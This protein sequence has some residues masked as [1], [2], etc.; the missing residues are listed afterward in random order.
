MTVF[1]VIRHGP[2]GWNAVG[3]VQGRSDIALSEDGRAVV[4][5]WAVPPDLSGF[6]RVT[7]PLSRAVETAQILFGEPVPQDNRLV[8]MNWAEWEGQS[9]TALRAEIGDL[10]V[11]WEARGLDFRAPSGES[12]RDVQL[13]LATLLA[14]VA[15]TEKPVVAVTHKG[16]I[17]ALYALATGWDMTDKPSDKL[18]DDCVHLFSLSPGGI[19][20]V[21]R[22]NIPLGAGE[23]P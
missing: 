16:V 3:R 7:S 9:L 1:A 11:A 5:G 10:V 22:L 12:P 14:E 23:R 15:L 8:E 21:D 18:R 4:A 13:R 20:M 2:T 17:G 6:E 19:P